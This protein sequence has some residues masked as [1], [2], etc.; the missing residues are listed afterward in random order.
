[1]LSE[2]NNRECIVRID[3]NGILLPAFKAK[4]V[5]FTSYPRP[6]KNN[7]IQNKQINQET[8]VLKR[9]WKTSNPDLKRVL[10]T[11]SQGRN[12]IGDENE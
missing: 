6:Q 7:T 1:M 4:T 2:L 11:S 10:E 9:K 5:D 3:S 12:N 8:N